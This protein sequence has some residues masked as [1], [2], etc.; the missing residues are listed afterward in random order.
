MA[1]VAGVSGCASQAQLVGAG[2]GAAIGAAVGGGPMATIGG[3][4]VG[5]GAGHVYDQRRN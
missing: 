3:A 5:Y 2:T 1:A 4:M